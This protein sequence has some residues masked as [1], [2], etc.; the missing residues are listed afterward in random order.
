VCLSFRVKTY[1]LIL[2]IFLEFWSILAGFS[3]GF[4][5]NPS[6]DVSQYFIFTKYSHTKIS[7]V[8][9]NVT[10]SH[11]FLNN[12]LSP[13]STPSTASTLRILP[14]KYTGSEILRILDLRPTEKYYKEIGKL[15]FII[16]SRCWRM[17]ELTHLLVHT[18]FATLKW[19]DP[20]YFGEFRITILEDTNFASHTNATM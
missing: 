2:H 13:P 4:A 5:V 8:V 1:F 9:T 3:C 16:K 17:Q 7:F 19:N 11:H 15:S 20:P 10:Q 14:E 6:Y 18:G 12:F